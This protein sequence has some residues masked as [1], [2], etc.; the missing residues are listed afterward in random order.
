VSRA[1]L[2]AAREI[3]A[4]NAVRGVRP[5][6]ALDG[7]PVGDGKPGPWSQRLDLL[8]EEDC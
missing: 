5:V 3:L 2:A 8:L 4:T 7:R 6:I 1:Q